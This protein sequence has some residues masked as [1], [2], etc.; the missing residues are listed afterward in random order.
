MKKLLSIAVTASLM[1]S[2]FTAS[3][4]NYSKHLYP[5]LIVESIA[6]VYDGDT[7]RANI[8]DVTP[9]LGDALPIHLRGVDTPEIRGKC[10]KER[11]LAHDARSLLFNFLTAATTIELRNI[12]RGKYF[13]V[14]ADVYIDE[15]DIKMIL[16][17]DGL[18]V[19]YDGFEKKKDW[20]K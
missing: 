5:D 6:S 2:S 19:P 12:K 17:N 1:L 4:V 18:G 20:C 11:L 13:S 10:D 9:L 8:S 15:L 14:V 16:I 3:G 7:F